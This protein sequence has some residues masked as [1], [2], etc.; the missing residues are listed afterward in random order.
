MKVQYLENPQECYKTVKAKY[1]GEDL[2]YKMKSVRRLPMEQ[3]NN[4]I[5]QSIAK[6]FMTQRYSELIYSSNYGVDWEKFIGRDMTSEL[7]LDIEDEIT[8]ALSVCEY[9]ESTKVSVLGV[10]GDK[11]VVNCDVTL[12]DGYVV[13][14]QRNI[15]I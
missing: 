4:P 10:G 6:R 2:K 9:I 3:P 1:D 15:Q 14:M 12:K 8:Q 5:I 7:A 11:V 13:N